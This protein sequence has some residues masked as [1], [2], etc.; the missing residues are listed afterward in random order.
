MDFHTAGSARVPRREHA[1]A[2][3]VAQNL[4]R[5]LGEHATAMAALRAEDCRGAVDPD[6]VRHWLAVARRIDAILADEAPASSA[7]R[8]M[9][10]IEFYRHRAT[11]AERKADCG[12]E[13]LRQDMIDIAMQW[14]DLAMQ[15]Q[16]L[17]ETAGAAAPAAVEEPRR[18]RQGSG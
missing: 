8:L 13:E 7:W 16:L 15:A 10:R 6:G 17:A 14:R 3:R 9:Q 1:E 12:A 18:R 11:Q 2:D 5:E 4:V